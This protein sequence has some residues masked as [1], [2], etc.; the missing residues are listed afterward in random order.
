LKAVPAVAVLGAETTS[1]ETGAAL[2]ETLLEV[3]VIDEVAVSVAVR[4][5]GPAVL[6]VAGKVPVPVLRVEFAGNAALESELVNFTVP[7]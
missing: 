7:E 5:W 4:V 1:W 6:N 2:T 3:P